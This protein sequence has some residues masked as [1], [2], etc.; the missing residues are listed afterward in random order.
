M[1]TKTEEEIAA[2]LARSSN[3]VMILH[4]RYSFDNYRMMMLRFPMMTK[5]KPV[6]PRKLE[7]LR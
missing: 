2:I 4:P 3:P 6:Q 1:R 7:S 5:T